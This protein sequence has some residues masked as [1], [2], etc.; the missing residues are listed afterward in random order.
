MSFEEFFGGKN[1]CSTFHKLK[2]VRNIA[3]EA[4]KACVIDVRIMWVSN[5]RYPITK[6]SNQT[7]VIGNPHDRTSIM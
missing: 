7:P 2:T 6:N 1:V 3:K 4:I 5:Y